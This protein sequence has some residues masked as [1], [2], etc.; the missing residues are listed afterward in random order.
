MNANVSGVS[1]AGAKSAFRRSPMAAAESD[2]VSAAI[3][4]CGRYQFTR[5]VVVLLA[6]VPGLCHIFVVIFSSI[7][8]DFWCDDGGRTEDAK[9]ECAANC[10]AYGFDKTFW[11]STLIS[12]YQ[13]VCSR[14]PLLRKALSS[15][16]SNTTVQ[17]DHSAQ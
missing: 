15:V 6:S 17:G 1:T 7:K 9:N 4:H 12:E 16:S 10:S 2:A 14:A 8:T 3:G 11:R 5:S 13:L